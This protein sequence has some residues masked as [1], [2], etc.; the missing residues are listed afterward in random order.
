[1]LNG[2]LDI[3]WKTDFR[4]AYTHSKYKYNKHNNNINSDCNWQLS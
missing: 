3:T 1:M 4:N 2:F